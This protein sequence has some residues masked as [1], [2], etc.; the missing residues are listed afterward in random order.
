MRTDSVKDANVALYSMG[1]IAG[2]AINSFSPRLL[3]DVEK[4][5]DPQG[6]ASF[7]SSGKTGLSPD[8]RLFVE[9]DPRVPALKNLV[10]LYATDALKDARSPFISFGFKCQKGIW[11]SPA[12]VE[13]VADHLSA[14]DFKV[15]VRHHGLS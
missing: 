7:R 2:N 8:V 11:I 3:F 15:L 12:I 4:F 9:D 1:R 14:L 10:A 6:V 5:R 13:I